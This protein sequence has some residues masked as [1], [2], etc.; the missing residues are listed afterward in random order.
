M[1][2]LASLTKTIDRSWGPGRLLTSAVCMVFLVACGGDRGNPPSPP[3]P[4][5]NGAPA[6]ASCG[7]SQKTE[8]NRTAYQAQ[9]ID[10]DTLTFSI[11][12]G[13]DAGSFTI[14]SAGNL[15]FNAPPNFGLPT[16]RYRHILA[17][18]GVPR[19]RFCHQKAVAI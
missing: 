14:G 16:D 5:S 4:P 13:A 18:S 6:I 9:A 10:G 15:V 17:R 19:Q 8:N 11:S 2:R 1:I 7:T 12:G 3:S